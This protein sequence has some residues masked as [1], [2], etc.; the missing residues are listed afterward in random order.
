MAANARRPSR[1]STELKVDDKLFEIDK[2][3]R[4]IVKDKLKLGQF[5]RIVS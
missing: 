2:I 4:G 1:L 3:A 5:L